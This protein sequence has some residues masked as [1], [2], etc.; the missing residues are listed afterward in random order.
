[1]VDSYPKR[2][3]SFFPQIKKGCSIKL[4]FATARVLH[5][6]GLVSVHMPSIFNE[7]ILSN[8]MRN[9]TVVDVRSLHPYYFEFG[10]KLAAL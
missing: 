8:L 10:F 4:P 6:Q 1:L 7:S 9:A 3:V 2:N 5:D